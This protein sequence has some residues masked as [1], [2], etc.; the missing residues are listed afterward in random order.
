MVEFDRDLYDRIINEN[1]QFP[2][3]PDQSNL[4]KV[5]REV[6][7]CSDAEAMRIAAWHCNSLSFYGLCR[8]RHWIEFPY[9]YWLTFLRDNNYINRKGYLV[10]EKPVIAKLFGFDDRYVFKVGSREV[11]YKESKLDQKSIVNRIIKGLESL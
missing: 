4:W 7:N 5:I 1:L 8:G 6:Y 10:K 3:F 11:L 2:D 9:M